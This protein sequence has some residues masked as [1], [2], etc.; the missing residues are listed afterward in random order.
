MSQP[1]C[2]PADA[3]AEA[4]ALL[5]V[6]RAS[7][8]ILASA[9]GCVAGSVLLQERGTSTWLDCTRT[10]VP[11]AGDPEAVS[12][13]RSGGARYVLVVEKQAVF[14]RLCEDRIWQ[15]LPV[16]L[17]CG[18]GVPD[19]STRMLAHRIVTQLRLPVL[20]LFDWNPGGVAVWSVWR[21]G[22]AAAGL[23]AFQYA[24]PVLW[25]GLHAADAAQLQL[26]ASI[27]VPMGVRDRKKLARLQTQPWLRASGAYM[28]ELEAMRSGAGKLELEALQYRGT[29]A[30]TRFVIDKILRRAYF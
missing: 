2:Q 5:R 28:R 19:L 16:V 25:L 1:R 29:A 18:C 17:L 12:A 6:P 14:A 3:H 26:P 15:R 22:S 9:R 10:P 30:L 23:E 11:V 4:V 27:Y 21:R 7:L 13:L 20:G 24:L 8:G